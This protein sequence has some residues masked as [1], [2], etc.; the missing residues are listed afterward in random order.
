VVVSNSS[1]LRKSAALRATL[2]SNT[3]I[4]LLHPVPY[5]PSTGPAIV[6]HLRANAA[7]GVTRPDQVVVIG[8]RIATDVLL[9]N[10]MGVRSIWVRDG[11]DGGGA[12]AGIER[13]VVDFLLRRGM[14]PPVCKSVFEGE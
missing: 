8:D 4:K 11:V 10:T 9:A 6:A 5:K 14:A 1:E 13:T 3:G 7:L 2:E 12:L